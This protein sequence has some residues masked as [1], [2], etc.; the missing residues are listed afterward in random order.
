M[1][2][3]LLLPARVPPNL[4]TC[5]SR[6]PSRAS[7]TSRTASR[8]PPLRRIRRSCFHTRTSPSRCNSSVP[9]TKSPPQLGVP[10]QTT[11][12]RYTFPSPF[13]QLHRI[14]HFN[15]SL[16]RAE[17]RS[18]RGGAEPQPRREDAR[19]HQHVSGVRAVGD[20]LLR[21]KQQR[22]GRQTSQACSQV[23]RDPGPHLPRQPSH[24]GQ[25]QPQRGS[26]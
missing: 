15:F 21:Q 20:R 23:Q 17:S 24:R 6:S 11:S 13:S 2:D 19:C 5:C 14:I 25:S 12:R 18:H 7:K 10:R 26:G 8:T 3:R 22:S 9:E 16:L 4:R 1:L